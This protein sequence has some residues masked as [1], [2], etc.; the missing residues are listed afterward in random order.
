MCRQMSTSNINHF[1]NFNFI[2]TNLG[3]FVITARLTGRPVHAP[4]HGVGAAD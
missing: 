2:G 4:V 3:N 1:I